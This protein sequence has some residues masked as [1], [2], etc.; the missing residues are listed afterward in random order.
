[1]RFLTQVFHVIPDPFLLWVGTNV[2]GQFGSEAVDEGGLAGLGEMLEG[3]IQ[4]M[5]H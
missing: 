1:M 3:F 4:G 2:L 5:T